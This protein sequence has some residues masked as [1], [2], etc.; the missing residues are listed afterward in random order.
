MGSDPWASRAEKVEKGCPMGH[1]ERRVLSN[2]S[3]ISEFSIIE[4]LF[5]LFNDFQ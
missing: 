4:F 5:V 1:A 2:H 3:A